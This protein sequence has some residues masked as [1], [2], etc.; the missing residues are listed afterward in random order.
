MKDWSS[1]RSTAWDA[2][3]NQKWVAE[4]AETGSGWTFRSVATGL[5]LSVEGT[6]RPNASVVATRE[7]TTWDL[8][9]ARD[10]STVRLVVSGPGAQLCVQ[11][12]S[13]G[14]SVKLGDLRDGG[15]A[16]Q[17]RLEKA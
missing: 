17:W 1:V 7:V 10:P 11:V 6:P 14:A 4:R 9:P 3:D 5:F 13:S 8:Y 12:G 16:Q 15:E 2:S